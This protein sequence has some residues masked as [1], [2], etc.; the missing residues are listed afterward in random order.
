MNKIKKKFQKYFAIFGIHLKNRLV[1]LYDIFFSGIFMVI[2]IFIFL[3][4]W[5]A[6]YG[7]GQHV[8]LCGYT[9]SD[10]IWYLVIAEAVILSLPHINREIDE[11][12]KSGTIACYLI[13][14]VNFLFYK[15]M[16]YL[17]EVILKLPINLIIGGILGLIFIG[18]PQSTINILP[19]LLII[20]LAITL[21]FIIKMLIGIMAFWIEDTG[22]I[23]WIYGKMIFTLGGLF[24]PL[25]FFPDYL[26][27]I[28]MKLPFRLIPYSI[29]RNCLNFKMD[30]FTETVWWFMIWLIPLLVLLTVLYAK[31]VKKLDIHGG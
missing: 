6:V 16:Q 3:N 28:C 12:V 25:E 24:I 29:S 5:K 23:A 10:M 15:Y 13:R 27:N 19:L 22:P 18:V 9:L 1:Y 30:V 7:S 11:Q 20:Y 2:I 31:G 21:D 14:P 17:A 8:K 4:L 26:K